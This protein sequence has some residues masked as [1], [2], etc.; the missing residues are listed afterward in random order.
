MSVIS[1][2]QADEFVQ[3]AEDGAPVEDQQLQIDALRQKLESQQSLIDELMK[4]LEEGDSGE[5]EEDGDLTISTRVQRLEDSILPLETRQ[6]DFLEA[7]ST[8]D[9]RGVNGRVHIDQWSFP[10]S[11]PGINVIENGDPTKDPQNRLLYRRIRFGVRGQVPPLNMSYRVEIEFSGQDGSQFRDAWI[12]WDDLMIFDTVRIGNQKRPYAWDHLNS[13]NFMVFLERPFI[14]DALNENNRR[15]GIVSYSASDDES[16]NWQ[17]GAYNLTEVQSVGSIVNDHAQV[18]IAGRLGNTWWYDESSNGRGYAHWA[19]AG[20]VAFPDGNALNEGGQ[21]NQARF[22]S[23]PEGRSSS[24]WLDTGRIAGA[25]AY[26]ILALESVFNAGPLQIAG[27][28]MTLR[29][30]RSDAA[31][32]DLRF[33]GGYLYASY[34][35]TGEHMPWNRKLGILGRVEPFEN[36]FSVETCDGCSGRGWGAWQVALRLSY[37]DFNSRD[38]LGGAGE[39]LTAALNWHW[40][41][42][43]RMQIN[44]VIGRIKDRSVDLPAGGN[45]VVSGR[46]QIAGVRFMIDF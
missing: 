43:S 39:S 15:F 21:N 1:P 32:A 3:P 20:T 5:D 13:S 25:D 41:S 19:V 16:F 38:V 22:R 46:Y 35:L 4:Q 23:R 42:H 28:F 34:F 6:S 33:H 9:R 2:A 31:S 12:G 45:A 26:E 30:Q 7:L 27:E 44:Y 11:T 36:F 40:N 10:A 18:E 37:A 14:V 29:L 8:A 24:H 17:Y